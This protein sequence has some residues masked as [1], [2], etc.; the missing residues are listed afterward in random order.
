MMKKLTS[1]LLSAA[2]LVGMLAYGASAKT[3]TTV[4][5]AGMDGADLLDALL[6]LTPPLT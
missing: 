4:R 5:V 3:N 2:L 6:G 1:L